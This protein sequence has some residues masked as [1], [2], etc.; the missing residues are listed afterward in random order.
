V[1]GKIVVI[2]GKINATATFSVLLKDYS[3]KIPSIVSNK[4]SEK[5]DISVNALYQKK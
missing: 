1:P 2:N 4:V 5:I 3:I